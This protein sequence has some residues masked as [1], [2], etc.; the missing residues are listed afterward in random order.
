MQYP[1]PIVAQNEQD[2]E[3]PEGGCWQSEEI[4]RNDVFGMIC[5]KRP[6]RL[7]RRPTSLDHVLGDRGF[8][9]IDPELE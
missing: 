3:H 9:D 6:P 7:G 8:G 1:P 2:K 5:Q 4:Q